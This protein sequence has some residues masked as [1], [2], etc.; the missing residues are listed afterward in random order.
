MPRLVLISDTHGQHKEVSIPDG[1]ILIHCGDLASYGKEHEIIHFG[2]WMRTLPHKHKILCPGNHDTLFQKDPRKALS[3][4]GPSIHY[5]HDRTITVEGIRI[6]GTAWQPYFY[7]WAF[8]IPDP[9]ERIKKYRGL[10][11][12]ADIVVTHTP[13]FGHLDISTRDD[14][15]G[16]VPLLDRIREIKPKIHCFGHIH[17]GYGIKQS[18]DIIYVNAS[19]CNSYYQPVN[20][21]IVLDLSKDEVT[22][23]EDPQTTG[24]NYVA[25]S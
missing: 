6:T 24:V 23:V 9:E 13:P 18:Q 4:L 14:R 16:C 17:E 20:K 11:S 19:T 21:P 8:N 25:D 2:I 22:L 1:D 15:C 5:I 7:D 10:D 3:L 12:K